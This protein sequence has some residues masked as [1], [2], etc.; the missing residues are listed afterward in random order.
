MKLTRIRGKQE[1]VMSIAIVRRVVIRSGLQRIFQVPLCGHF[2]FGW[3]S[4][5][6]CGKACA[7]TG[8]ELT[9]KQKWN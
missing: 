8:T 1:T 5:M 7:S 4:R 9:V 2:C 3:F 6:A